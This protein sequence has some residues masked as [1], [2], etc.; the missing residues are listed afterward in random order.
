MLSFN[1]FSY[2]F[3]TVIGLFRYKNV[4]KVSAAVST[5][6]E[7]HLE[8]LS[9]SW[10]TL[11]YIYIIFTCLSTFLHGVETFTD[12]SVCFLFSFIKKWTLYY[13]MFTLSCLTENSWNNLKPANIC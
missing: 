13:K 5:G 4:I 11:F 8:I 12:R 10:H 1:P 7:N 9:L 3:Y 6:I 2:M